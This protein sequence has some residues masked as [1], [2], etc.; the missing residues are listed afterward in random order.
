[1]VDIKIDLKEVDCLGVIRIHLAQ[2]SVQWRAVLS[3]VMN[4]RVPQKTGIC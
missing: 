2:N 1:M 4:I 3:T